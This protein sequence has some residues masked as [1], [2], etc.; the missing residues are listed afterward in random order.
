MEIVYRTNAALLQ[1]CKN[2]YP[3]DHM[4][5]RIPSQ[6]LDETG[7][8]SM[9][10]QS[11][12]GRVQACLQRFL[13]S[14]NSMKEFQE[15]ICFRLRDFAAW[16]EK[17]KIS[18]G[19]ITTEDAEAYTAFLRDQF[20]Y[21]TVSSYRGMIRRFFNLAVKEKLHTENPFG[22][23]ATRSSRHPIPS[24]NIPASIPAVVRKA[25]PKAVTALC[26]CFQMDVMGYRKCQSMAWSIVEFL[27]WLESQD[28][29]LVALDRK[30]CRRYAQ[31]LKKRYA[32]STIE[33]ILCEINKL[34]QQLV[35]SKILLFNPVD[36]KGF[37]GKA[38]PSVL[39]QLPRQEEVMQLL[40]SGTLNSIS[41]FRDRAI[42]SVVFYAMAEIGEI[43]KLRV[44]DFLQKDKSWWLRFP[45]REV[46]A[47]SELVDHL[48]S[49]F[50]VAGIEVGDPGP[51]FRET[52]RKGQHISKASLS[53]HGIS[54]RFTL[55]CK[56]LCLPTTLRAVAV[57]GAGI[58]AFL[59]SGGTIQKAAT[60]T[61][62][63][64]AAVSRY[65]DKEPTTLVYEGDLDGLLS[66]LSGSATEPL[67]EFAKKSGIFRLTMEQDNKLEEE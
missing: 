57:R 24:K 17:N 44:C 41:D 2:Q 37:T 65:I 29:S 63:S 32:R 10:F 51:L 14:F 58:K 61:G 16:C 13:S 9:F 27:H 26:A 67:Q 64:L 36:T 62:L 1:F 42:F 4:V 21:K 40:N 35:K 5:H 66:F 60:L 43:T 7:S 52:Q 11:T 23:S 12:D 25:G 33:K 50:R 45:N 6:L 18:F 59:E 30:T 53:R 20:A 38:A 34:C 46:P 54:I 39:T 56:Q 55:R 31:G 47:N 28:L 48:L 3:E 19:E 15:R 8:L 49:Y 22:T